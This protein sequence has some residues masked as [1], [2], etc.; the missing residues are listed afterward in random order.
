MPVRFEQTLLEGNLIRRYKRFM[1]DVE[2]P[3]GSVVTAHCANSGSMATC[4]DPGQ[5]VL[6]L[7]TDSP[8]RKLKY[9]WELYHSGSCWVGVNTHRP[10]AL[11]A[12]AIA[13]G[14]VP[15]L[16]GYAGMRREVKYG[17][18]SRI[19]ILLE[20]PDKGPCHV[21]VKNCTLLAPDGMVRFPDAVTERGRKHLDELME[22]AAEGGRA[23][24]FFL[25]NR[26]DG[27][28][29]GPADHIDPDYGKRLREAAEAGVELL[30]YRTSITPEGMEVGTPE[31]V[32][33]RP[34]HELSPS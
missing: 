6:L 14:S 8:K 11:V 27:K 12:E 10:N 2:L 3:D 21:E 16:A 9:T 30:A 24:M 13:A 4:K 25:V 18:N 31:A 5:P 32:D 23:V 28:G 34:A 15:E 29:F 19:D 22:L 26:T 7:P 1:A 33:L 17:R 20:D